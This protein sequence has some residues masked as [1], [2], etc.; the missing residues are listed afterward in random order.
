[1]T[2]EEL[3]GMAQR[4]VSLAPGDIN[5]H[6]CMTALLCHTPANRAISAEKLAMLLVEYVEQSQPK[7]VRH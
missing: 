7:K 5:L 2:Y 6:D 4:A 1:M 3:L